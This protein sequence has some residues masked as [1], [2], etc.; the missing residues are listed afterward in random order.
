MC[1]YKG[2][3]SDRAQVNHN[4]ELTCFAIRKQN[5]CN[6]Y[7][8]DFRRLNNYIQMVCLYTWTT[9]SSFVLKLFPIGLISH[10]KKA[11]QKKM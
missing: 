8:Y 11:E 9:S 4:V 5:E 1:V 2:Q 7:I 10:L 6:I 3:E